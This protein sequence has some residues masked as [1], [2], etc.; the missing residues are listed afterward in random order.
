MAEAQAQVGQLTISRVNKG[1]GLTH[2]WTEYAFELK[3]Y[4]NFSRLV[5]GAVH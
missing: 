5:L 2:L 3:N 4:L 1:L